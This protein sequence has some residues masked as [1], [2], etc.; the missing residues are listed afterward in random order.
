MALGDR[1]MGLSDLLSEEQQE[2]LTDLAEGGTGEK[3]N[4]KDAE[5]QSKPFPETAW[6]GLFAT[7]REIVVPSTEAAPENLWSMFL[8]AVG[9]MLGRNVWA[10]LPREIYPNFFV[11]LTGRTGDPRKST[12]LELLKQ[13]LK[14]IGEDQDVEVLTG[15][16]STEG[17]FEALAKTERKRALVFSDEFRSLLCIAKG[18]KATQDLLPKLN[19]LYSCPDFDSI[20]RKERS[21]RIVEP[22]VSLVT[23]TARE[24]VEDLLG[25]LD[26][27]G[28]MLNRFI[29]VEGKT[30]PPKPFAKFPSPEHWGKLTGP[31]CKVRDYWKAN[32]SCLE[33]DSRAHDLWG[34]WYIAWKKERDELDP[35]RRDLTARTSEHVLKISLVYSAL[36]QEREISARSLITGI[37][38]GEWLEGNVLRAF[39]DVG[40]DSFSKAEK[41]I[42][43]KIRSKGRLFRRVLQQAAG[44][45]GIN[46]RMFGDVLKTLH[47]NGHIKI[48]GDKALSGQKTI[49][50][51]YVADNT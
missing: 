16:V 1:A 29:I 42:L 25:N 4:R 32:P 15:L 45:R 10:I 11:L 22:F 27:V 51:E 40:L 6:T 23:A 37:K 12:A 48:T 36:A 9:L 33:F 43:S 50:V 34:E 41:L 46:A 39:E 5:D 2:Q 20:N 44:A 18:R 13:T 24:Y 30:Q 47:E 19:S 38:I 31:L 7:W 14:R 49:L 8:V 26:V 17:L 21:T 28:G 35:K 3:R